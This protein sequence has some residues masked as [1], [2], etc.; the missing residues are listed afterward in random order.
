MPRSLSFLLLRT[1]STV[2]RHHAITPAAGVHTHIHTHT[3]K[4]PPQ[5]DTHKK[6]GGRSLP[7]W[8]DIR[9]ERGPHVTF[10]ALTAQAQDEAGLLRSRD[11]L[12][13]L[14]EAETTGSTSSSA[15]NSTSASGPTSGGG[16]AAGIPASQVLVGGFSQ[17][18]VMALLAGVSASSAAAAAAGSALGGVF[19]LSGYLALADAVTGKKGG[20]GGGGGGGGADS[21]FPHARAEG[22]GG[23]ATTE[24]LMVHG[25]RDPVMNLG[26][27]R[28]SAGAVRG[29]GYDVDLVVVPYV[30]SSC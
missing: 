14:V 11:F 10:E 9:G 5:A 24:V 17:G 19:C 22:G 30:F 6:A 29:L 1:P 16:G 23:E 2:S 8:F 27:A 15:P 13:S 3:H 18:G 4:K 12:L 25:D 20:G 21:E 7:A 26:W 28:D